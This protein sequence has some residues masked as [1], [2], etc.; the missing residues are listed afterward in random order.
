MRTVIA[1][2]LSLAVAAGAHAADR[3]PIVPSI[4]EVVPTLPTITVTD[5]SQPK[6]QADI[7]KSGSPED[8]TPAWATPLLPPDLAFPVS[9]AKSPRE[10]AADK[11]FD[12]EKD[13]FDTKQHARIAEYIGKATEHPTTARSAGS[14]TVY[15]FREGDIYIVYAGLDRLTDIAL[16]PGESLT[17]DPVAGDTEGWIKSQFTSGSG[18]NARTHIVVKPRDEGIETNLIVPTTK[19]VYQIDLRAKPDWFMPAVRWF[20][21]DEEVAVALKKEIDEQTKQDRSEALAVSP[22]RL[23]FHYKIKGRDIAW[24]PA[25]VFDDGT[26]VYLKMP[27]D[28]ATGDAPALFV[29]EDGKPLLVNYRVKDRFYIVDRLFAKAQLRV[30]DRQVDVERCGAHAWFCH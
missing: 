14:A 3:Q 19:R 28:L 12:K 24:K 22:E 13:A 26:K 7:A 18:A 9:H 29:L 16:Q 30:G 1:F 21:P 10:T 2:A 17:A 11:A 20:Y 4:N 8:A 27:E 23:N 6:P 25:Q 5:S 15:G